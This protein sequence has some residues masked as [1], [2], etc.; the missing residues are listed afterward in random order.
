MSM[1]RKVATLA[2]AAALSAAPLTAPAAM[3]CQCKD[4][5]ASRSDQQK[6]EQK[7][8]S[9]YQNPSTLNDQEYFSPDR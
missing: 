1:F 2:V 8:P 7:S 6:G 5:D 3:Q 4:D 9:Y